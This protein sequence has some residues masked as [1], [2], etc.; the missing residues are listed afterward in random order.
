[1]VTHPFVL[2]MGDGSLDINKF[3]NYFR[4]DYVF[5]KDLVK[6]TS[7]AIARAAPDYDAGQDAGN[8]FLDELSVRRERPV[9]QRFSRPG[10]HGRAIPG[11]RGQPG[12]PGVSATSWCV[13]P[14]RVTSTTCMALFY[15]TEG[16]YLDWADPPHRIR[17]RSPTTP[18]TRAGSTSTAP[19]CWAT[20]WPGSR[21]VSTT[22]DER[23]SANKARQPGAHLPHHP[24]LRVPVLGSVLPR[25]GLA[26][27]EP[28][29]GEH[30]PSGPQPRIRPEAY[31]P[32]IA[33]P[34][35]FPSS[36][37]LPCTSRSTCWWWRSTCWPRRGTCGSIGP[38][39]AGESV[40]SSTVWSHCCHS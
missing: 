31:R 16:T 37:T 2:E 14:W 15:V 5:C 12:H 20:W 11:N 19:T 27:P 33:S 9:P 39:W 6:L 21:S 10:R 25:A 18:C 1:M 7:I 35:N 30:E 29:G 32:E 26:R 22:P 17:E 40:S 34:P 36:C 24:A 13:P 4:Q 23:A 28:D 8:G 3:R 38:C